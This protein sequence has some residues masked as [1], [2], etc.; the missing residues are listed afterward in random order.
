MCAGN[1]IPTTDE[2]MG[3][4]ENIE[5]SQN[6]K[7][8]IENNKPITI[9]FDKLLRNLEYRLSC[10][11][12]STQA[13]KTSRTGTK[14]IRNMISLSSNKTLSTLKAADTYPTLCSE[15]SL[16]G[17]LNNSRDVINNCQLSMSTKGFANT[18]CPVCTDNEGQYTSPGVYLSKPQ[19]IT[20][21]ATSR[22]RLLQTV[23][24]TN[25]N[26]TQ[27]T[28]PA[29][30]VVLPNKQS[31]KLCIV[32][33]PNCGTNPDV[34]ME[35]YKNRFNNLINSYN[36]TLESTTPSKNLLIEKVVSYNDT[37]PDMKKLNI[38][39]LTYQMNGYIEW[40]AT[41]PTPLKCKW[42][43]RL[44]SFISSPTFDY[45]WSCSNI[46]CGSSYVNSNGTLTSTDKSKLFGLE[47]GSRYN[48]YYACYS[49]VPNAMN[50]NVALVSSFTTPMPTVMPVIG[51]YYQSFYW[52]GA[53]ILLLIFL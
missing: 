8:Y 28:T 29:T 46:N 1:N 20:Q 2:I 32:Q 30:N 31:I 23:T 43:Y 47:Q 34:S 3:K 24:Q 7:T 48:I 22:L 50:G 44:E 33:N 5:K 45:I 36:N 39:S 51:G 38:T 40:T 12:E 9:I 4:Y 17:I 15:I 14:M 11:L 25:T 27:T 26:T 52:T 41:Y 37:I 6:Y 13:D 21:Q 53:L 10:V 16:N 42:M 19:C 35:E 49:D 18:G